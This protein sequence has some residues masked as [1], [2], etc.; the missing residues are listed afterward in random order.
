MLDGDWSSDVCSSD[1]PEETSRGIPQIVAQEKSLFRARQEGLK[2]QL[3]VVD[4]QHRQRELELAE[5]RTRW[6]S[7]QRERELVSQRVQSLRRLTKMGAISTNELLENE[8]S[9]QQIEARI[10]SILLDIP[11]L[12][13][14]VS[15][16]ARRREETTLRFR[17]ESEK[18]QREA[19]VQL[20]KLEEAM[21]AMRD[22]SRRSEVVAPVDGVVNKLFV[23][24]IGGVVKSGEPLVQIVPVESSVVVEA[25]VSPQDRANVWPGLP[26]VV[27]VSAYDFAVYGGLKGKV[28]DVSPD[29]LSDDKGEPYFRVRLAADATALGPNRPVIPGMTAQVDIISG[30]HTVLGYLLKPVQRLKSEALRQ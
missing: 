5:M 14:A 13:A 8:R 12:E 17:A 26:A 16:L 22:R 18:E 2:A 6:T 30:S 28:L 15:E 20:A 23:D 1:L 19:S 9:L 4:E 7:T 11:R 29:A 24:T 25:R 27:K 21:N 3:A 10:A